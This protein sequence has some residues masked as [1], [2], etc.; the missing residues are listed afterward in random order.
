M[1]ARTW[2]GVAKTPAK[3]DSYE[4]HVT[5]EVLPAL[6]SIP[7]HRGGRVLRRDDGGRVEFLVITMW[8][9][10]DA[11]RAFAGA[12]PE[13]A[14]VE[15]DARAVL[16]EFDE[17]VR[18]YELVEGAYDPA[19]GAIR[20]LYASILEAWNAC[21]AARMAAQFAAD[22]NLVGFDGSQVDSRAAIEAHLAPIFADHP[23]A[24]YVAKV[25]E[26]RMLGNSAGVLRAVAG[27]VRPGT[28]DV[29]PPLHTIHTLVAAQA[30][31]GVW[32][33]AL[34]QSTP[35]AWHGRPADVEALTEELRGVHRR[36]RTLE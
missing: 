22:G 30:A 31:N 9:S 23:T 36:G 35:A 20:G 2:R 32:R 4:R 7:G 29:H 11:I 16:A 33:A 1:I 17:V 5:H 21:D 19:T 24:P 12:H 26:I 10:M 25:R 3:A 8:D 6:T 27:M 34:F 28:D 14:V 18:H 15:P 13:K